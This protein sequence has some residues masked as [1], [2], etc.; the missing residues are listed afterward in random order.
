M[1]PS[2]YFFKSARENPLIYYSAKFNRRGYAGESGD[3]TTEHG[4]G[5][6][7]TGYWGYYSAAICIP[8]NWKF[9]KLSDDAQDKIAEP[10]GCRFSERYTTCSLEGYAMIE[11][12]FNLGEYL[13]IYCGLDDVLRDIKYVIENITTYE[14]YAEPDLIEG[15]LNNLTANISKC[16]ELKGETD[17]LDSYYNLKD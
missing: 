10:Y 4:I 7:N 11:W 15:M 3:L 6:H 8:N 12:E 14:Y 2:H 17:E 1:N 5:Q 16:R 13:E 9:V